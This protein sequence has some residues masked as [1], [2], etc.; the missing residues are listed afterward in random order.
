MPLASIV[1]AAAGAIN[2]TNAAVKAVVD[3]SNSISLSMEIENCTEFN[4]TDPDVQLNCGMMNTPPGDIIAP[5]GRD[6]M[7]VHQSGWFAGSSGTVS[8]IIDTEKVEDRRCVVVMWSLP[9]TFIHSV[10]QLAV[11]ITNPGDLDHQFG[12]AWFNLMYYD[13]KEQVDRVFGYERKEFYNDINPVNFEDFRFEV[14][15]TLGSDHHA[16]AKIILRPKSHK[17]LTPREEVGINDID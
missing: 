13:K 2:A 9:Y 16:K 8:W 4:L 17:E 10:N 14:A 1:A 7:V 12:N 6:T 3:T 11:G 15:G 5:T